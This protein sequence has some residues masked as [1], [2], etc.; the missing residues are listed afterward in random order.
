MEG[1]SSAVAAKA[2]VDSV[3]TYSCKTQSSAGRPPLR[4]KQR[5]PQPRAT[6]ALDPPLNRLEA[7]DGMRCPR[8]VEAMTALRAAG[9][10]SAA[11][12]LTVCSWSALV[13]AGI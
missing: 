11:G 6:S 4:P 1:S 9:T 13:S 7:S 2:V 12:L 10:S 5:Q 3:A 8:M